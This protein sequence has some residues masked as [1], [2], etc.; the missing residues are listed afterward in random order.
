MDARVPC[1]RQGGQESEEAMTTKKVVKKTAEKHEHKAQ[2][3]E[4]PRR[5]IDAAYTLAKQDHDGLFEGEKVVGGDEPKAESVS[6]EMVEVKVKGVKLDPSTF[7]KVEGVKLD[8]S[9]FGD[10][11]P[12]VVNGMRG[13]IKLAPA[14]EI[15]THRIAILEDAI[16]LHRSLCH[17]TG[18]RAQDHALHALV[19]VK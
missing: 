10:D 3:A 15:L 17:R 12:V 5:E 14:V 11:V 4:T 2:T 18:F 13:T 1:W 7:G 6:P 8:P 9:T 16:K 19:L